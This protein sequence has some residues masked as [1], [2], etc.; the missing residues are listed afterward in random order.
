MVFELTD[1]EGKDSKIQ[2]ISLY[3]YF[4][5]VSICFESSLAS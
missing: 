5:I 3:L 1:F 4:S 2:L